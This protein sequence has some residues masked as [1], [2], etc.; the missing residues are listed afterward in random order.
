MTNYTSISCHL[1]IC[2]QK[3]LVYECGNVYNC[4]FHVDFIL[5]F[6][7]RVQ[8]YYKEDLEH[9]NIWFMAYVA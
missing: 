2:N 5:S 8:C 6:K 3:Y 1:F 7:T 9:I 4:A